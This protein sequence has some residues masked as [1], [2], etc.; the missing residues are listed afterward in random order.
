VKT[1]LLVA[2]ARPNFIKLAPLHEALSKRRESY[3]PFLVHT[4]Q[5][6]D[7]RMSDVFFR[8][9]G[10]PKPDINLGVGSGSHG[11]QTGKV[12]IA[13]EEVML[14]LDPDMVVVFGDI[15]ST[16]AAAITAAKLEIPVAHVEAGLR[17]NDW[18]MPEEINRIVADRVSTLH[19]TTCED[20][21]RNLVREGVA[22]DSI[23]FVGNIMIDSLSKFLSMAENTTVTKDMNLSDYILIT[24]HRPGNVD[25]SKQLRKIIE[26][27]SGLAELAP[28]VFP[29]HPR[30][31]KNIIEFELSIGG[32]SILG[33]KNLH[34]VEPLGYLE[35]LKLEKNAA[36]VVTDS[37]GVQE[38]TTYLGVPCLTVR[39]NTERP[40]TIT[41]GTNT[42][43]G[44]DP[45]RVIE[46]AGE[47]IDGRSACKGRPIMWDG[48][49]A[50]RIVN[51]IDKFFDIDSI[52]VEKTVRKRQERPAQYERHM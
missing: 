52:N 37:G 18:S 4:G 17:S 51:A 40:V 9:L 39:P 27:L 47:Y 19:F 32:D 11:L 41:D 14:D 1:I 43:V 23:H 38:E 36:V 24:M 16:L 8:Q 31:R 15:N 33:N 21:N 28:V 2:G 46:L 22:E 13:I 48:S 44:L 50:P 6:Y 35:F 10:L 34:L 49:T 20:A 25:D 45:T 3:R 42:L 29:I 12:M 7:D 30:T 26:I 5:H